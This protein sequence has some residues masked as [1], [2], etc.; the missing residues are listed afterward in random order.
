M[1]NEI[2]IGI[3]QTYTLYHLREEQMHV[4]LRALLQYTVSDDDALGDERIEIRDKLINAI[5]GALNDG[6]E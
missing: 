3:V 4:I 2:A 6:K 1:G 5:N